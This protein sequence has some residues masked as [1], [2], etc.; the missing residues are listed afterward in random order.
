[1]AGTI[2]ET[3]ERMQTTALKKAVEIY[4]ANQA[5]MPAKTAT[6]LNPIV[7]NSAPRYYFVILFIAVIVYFLYKKAYK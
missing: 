5:A 2:A 1:M 4:K 3:L 6:V 7:S